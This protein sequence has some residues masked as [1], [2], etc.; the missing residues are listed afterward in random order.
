MTTREEAVARL[1]APGAPYEIRVEDVR[2][3]DLEVYAHRQ[4]SLRELLEASRDFGDAEY[5]VTRD[6][7]ISFADHYDEVAALAHVLRTE[8]G[9][10][11]G[12]RVALCAANCPEWI[13]GFWAAVSIG[14]VAVGMNSMWAQPELVHGLELT[15]PKVLI[16]DAPRARMADGMGVRVLTVEEDLPRITAA[17]R[18]VALPQPDGEIAE[19]DP[20][21]ILFTSGTTGRAKGATHSHRN[22]IAAVWFHLL[23]DA[24]A[25]E[26]GFPQ[27]DRRF[28]LVTPLFHIAALHNLAVVRLVVG[29]TAVLHLG[30]FDI[31]QVLRLIESERVTNW[32]AM[33]TMLSRIVELGDRLAEFDLSSLRSISVG[34]APSSPE[35]KEALR[36]ALPAAGRSLGTTYGLTESSTAA[37]LALAAELAADPTTVGR[38]V[39]TVQ[40]EVRDTA[41]LPVPDGVEGEIHLR[42]AQLMLGYWDNPEATAASTA[43]HG[44]FR[45]GDLG[46]LTD[47]QLHISSRRSDLILRGGENIY[48]AEVEDRIVAHPAVRECIVMGVPDPDYGQGV[49]A[50]VVLHPGAQVSQEELCAHTAAGLARYKVPTRWQITL[51]ELPRN[52]TGK[53]NRRD[54][55]LV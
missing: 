55:R 54:V 16:A 30:K 5:L 33:P 2:G 23:N 41:G 11:R 38:P 44:W 18:G 20:A 21:V 15:T 43:P 9:V 28:L 25:A 35:L 27:V 47:G 32:G 3:E 8:H 39:P 14:A 50:V 36:Q 49:A 52:A 53:V 29:D 51:E 10:G 6:R 19:D 12:D 34:S 40:V 45:T 26:M 17:H 42:G 24:I 46:H 4:H 1:T 22:V 7:R 48:P 31:E 37:T 13:V